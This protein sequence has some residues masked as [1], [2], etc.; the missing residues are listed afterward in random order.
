MMLVSAWSASATTTLSVSSSSRR[1]GSNLVS[2]SAF[3]TDCTKSVCRNWIAE[4]LQAT[5]MSPQLA[6][7][8]Q[9]RR[10]THSPSCTIRPRS[11]AMPMNSSGGIR[12]WTGWRQR[13]SA[14]TPWTRAPSA[15]TWGW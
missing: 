13:T 15:E 14:S 2:A 10:I 6:A 5:V 1:D 8:M 12:P 9:A 3:A 11:S 4:T 7:S